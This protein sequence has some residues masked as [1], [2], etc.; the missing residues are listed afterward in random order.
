MLINVKYPTTKPVD[1]ISAQPFI[2][3]STTGSVRKPVKPAP[4]LGQCHDADEC[5]RGTQGCN[6]AGN[7]WRRV[8]LHSFGNHIRIE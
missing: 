8:T 7:L 4:E 1:D 2:M 5:A 3:L 6:P